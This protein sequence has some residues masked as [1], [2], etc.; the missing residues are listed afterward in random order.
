MGTAGNERGARGAGR[1]GRGVLR[2]RGDGVR[3]GRRGRPAGGGGSPA[4][5]LDLLARED[6]RGGGRHAVVA[7]GDGTEPAGS[8]PAAAARTILAPGAGPG[9]GRG[10]RPP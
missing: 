5:E 6:L 9:R 1:F 2:G 8:H 7:G 4:V 3:G 10:D